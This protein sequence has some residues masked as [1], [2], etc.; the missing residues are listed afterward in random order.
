MGERY[1]LTLSEGQGL[2]LASALRLELKKLRHKRL[3]LIALCMV[4]M[5]L[6]WLGHGWF[7]H[8]GGGTTTV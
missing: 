8:R 6:L 5:Q 4:A 3:W 7:G 1:A 2:A